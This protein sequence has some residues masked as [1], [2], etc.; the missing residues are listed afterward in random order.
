[1]QPINININKILAT[2]ILCSCLSAEIGI[3]AGLNYGG[4]TYSEDIFQ[5]MSIAN[6]VGAS[7]S[8]EKSIGPTV[9]GLGFFQ[10]SYVENF[11]YTGSALSGI[12]LSFKNTVTTSYAVGYVVY[13]YDISKFRFFGGLQFGQLLKGTSRVKLNGLEVTRDI[14]SDECYCGRDLM[15]IVFAVQDE[16]KSFVE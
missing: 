4:V 2:I 9:V 16:R 6:G 1:M 12:S 14:E 5:Y 3:V 11:S 13:P 8:L 7:A 15:S 10:Q